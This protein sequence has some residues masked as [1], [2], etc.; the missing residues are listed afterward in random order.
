MTATD[1]R[2]DRIIGASAFAGV[3][4]HPKQPRYQFTGQGL[5]NAS[6]ALNEVVALFVEHHVAEIVADVLN[7]LEPTTAAEYARLED[8]VPLLPT[9]EAIELP[10]QP[11]I[12][13]RSG[14]SVV[15][16]ACRAD[17]RPATKEAALLVTLPDCAR[18]ALTEHRHRFIAEVTVKGS[19]KAAIVDADDAVAVNEA[20]PWHWRDDHVENL[21]GVRL[22]DFVMEPKAWVEE[23]GYSKGQLDCRRG[24]LGLRPTTTVINLT[25]PTATVAAL[26]AMTAAE[27]GALFQE[28]NR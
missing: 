17:G 16:V 5:A 4:R 1:Y 25:V 9:L 23:V 2:A 7:R 13:L 21:H 20:A 24:R 28:S 27:I 8:L 6:D 22:G 3:V 10:R 11:E 14:N 12:Q 26:M 19:P 15:G 18:Q